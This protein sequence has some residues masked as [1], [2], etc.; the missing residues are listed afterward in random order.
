[1]HKATVAAILK[2][3]ELRSEQVNREAWKG[4]PPLPSVREHVAG[5]LMSLANRVAPAS[6]GSATPLVGASGAARP[7]RATPR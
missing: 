1:M 5:I 6:P 4:Q 2:E 3:H 7:A